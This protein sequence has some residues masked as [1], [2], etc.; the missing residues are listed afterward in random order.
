[1]VPERAA[2]V[3][4]AIVRTTSAG[5]WLTVIHGTD[6]VAVQ[7]H[8]AVTLARCTDEAEPADTALTDRETEHANEA[9]TVKGAFTATAAGFPEMPPLQPVKANP[10]VGVAL[11]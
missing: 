3:F 7:R 4:S 8:G 2:P 10:A 9:A 1:M 6:E 11:S 5:V